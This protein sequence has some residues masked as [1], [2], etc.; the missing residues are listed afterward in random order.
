MKELHVANDFESF[1]V[2]G[3]GVITMEFME[4]FENERHLAI[5]R[6]NL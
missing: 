3:G 4:N 1:I 2:Y 6:H 5:I